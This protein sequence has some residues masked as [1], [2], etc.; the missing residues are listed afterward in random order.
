MGDISSVNQYYNLFNKTKGYT[1]LLFRAGRVLQSKELNEMQ[2][3]IRNQIKNIGDT[4]L[5]NG[6]IIE[7][8]QLVING[9]SVTVTKGRI[10]LDGNVREIPNKTIT[11]TGVG[12]EVIGALLRKDVVTPNEDPELNEVASGYDNYNQDGAYRLK[13]VV[14]IVINNPAASILYNLENGQQVS[15]NTAEDLTQIDKINSTL[16]RRTYDESG[17]YKVSGLKLVDKKHSDNEKIY[18]SLE[19][20]RA[21]VKGFEV[22][23]TNATLVG[24][25]RALYT[26]RVDN[27]PK[28]FR[29]DTTRYNLNNEHVKDV[30]KLVAIVSKTSS[31]TRG[32]IVGGIDYLPLSPVVEVTKVIQ[33]GATYTLG[34]DFQLTN[35]G[36]D[37]SIGSRAPSTGSSYTVTW[38]YNKVMSK[39]TDFSIK[40]SGDNDVYYLEF[41]ITGDTPVNGSTF[42]VNY[43]FYLC[44]RD[45]ISLDKDGRVIVTEGQPD[46]LRTVE[47]PSVGNEEVLVL[48]SV[49]IKPNNNTPYII[50][51][52]TQTITMLELYNMLERIN[53]LEYNQA[54]T[55]LDSEA[56][57]NEN[58]SE[59][60]GVFTDGFLGFTKSD[61]F[62]SEW[63][64]SIDLDNNECTL[65]YTE[66]LTPLVIDKENNYKAG[67]FSR[68]I[69]APYEE[70]T[71]LSQ[72]LATGSIRVNSY[73]AFPKNPSVV[74]NPAVD[75]WIDE[76]HITIQGTNNTASVKLRR[77]WYHKGESWAA[78]EKAKW[79]S[80]GFSDGGESLRWGGGTGTV[81]LSST[82]VLDTAVLY[83]RQRSVS[84]TVQNLEP[85]VDNI[86]ATFDGINIK[87]TPLS[88]T[89][90]GTKDGSLKADPSGV[91]KG[92]F[93]VPANTLCGTRE[94]RVYPVSTPSLTGSANYIS[95]GRLR[96]T[97]TTVWNSKTTVTPTDPLAQSF[98]FD[99]DHYLTG[100]GLYFLD[101]NNSEPI[102][103]QVRGMTNG[104]PNTIVHT[105][106]IVYPNQIRT[107]TNASVETKVKFDNPVYCQANTQYCF[108]ILSNSDVDSVW[109]AETTKVDINSASQVSKNPYLNGCLFSSSNA[110]T[111]T[112]HQSSDMK[113]NIYG[114]QFEDEGTA[115]FEL[116]DN[117][118]FDRI[119]IMSEESIPAGCSI[120]WK[121]KINDEDWMPIETYDDRSLLEKA[122]KVLVKVGISSNRHTS[123]AIALDSLMLVGFKN[124][125][126][127]SY[128]SKNVSIDNG[129]NNIKIVVDLHI[130]N[131]T[132]I[133]M[134]YA[135]DSDGTTWNSIDSTKVDVK[136]SDYKSYTFEKRLST[137]AK[138]YRVKMVLN[139][140]DQV[141]VPKAKNLRNILKSV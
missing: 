42:L 78:A 19:M 5:T 94:L 96:T 38:N 28:V 14:D 1:E 36:I 29:T 110:M 65:P 79:Q 7:G 140:N 75:N 84:V 116:V 82:N 44:R 134:F 35:D 93:T 95:N 77:W 109:I 117:A 30:N 111:W 48:G 61:T 103:V 76:N 13:E 127:G 99:I 135:T 112:A 63:T 60:I 64:A 43:E 83:M 17:N 58:S 56:A 50:N 52:N 34:T 138:N 45:T 120:S 121:Y 67:E 114:A 73:N 122:N 125:L 22:S 11:I 69:T 139:T 25:N 141:N 105:E 41:S 115:T 24:I 88:S 85:N 20:G 53:T 128:V 46:I 47:S 101:K 89:Y 23:K 106:K 100:V 132:N 6:D 4:L 8:C 72:N 12:N 71:L 51:N 97:T 104:Y 108:T 90:K 10:Y 3:I 136:S 40:K 16:A 49:L 81:N 68:L 31:I 137:K 98:Q 126:T 107:S 57:K 18:I 59:L 2:S 102:T 37:W 92:S 66:T 39:G 130:P 74:L 119:M 70:I 9:T 15:V 133:N 113:F 91:A 33:G 26:R 80:Y 32:S 55:D 124:Q 131:G 62:H 123:P 27:E 118:S 54:I 87:L 21:Y 86:V 129:F